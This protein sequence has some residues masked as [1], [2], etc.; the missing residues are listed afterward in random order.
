MCF[1]FLWNWGFFTIAIDPSLPPWIMVGESCGKPSSLYRLL[2]QHASRPA[3]DKAMYS[4][5]AVDS[6]VVLCFL[7]IQVI[8][9]PPTV[10]TYLDIDF[11]L[12]TLLY[13]ASAYP[14]KRFVPLFFRGDAEYVIPYV[15]VPAR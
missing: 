6:A 3:S 1:D 8:A 14:W 11:H 13:A 5:S 15:L 12:S 7:D 10:K 9:P 4:A 2:N